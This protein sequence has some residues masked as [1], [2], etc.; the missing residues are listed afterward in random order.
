MSLRRGVSVC[1][2][3]KPGKNVLRA[4]H[5][6]D[7]DAAHSIKNLQLQ[8]SY[9]NLYETPE[10]L[11]CPTIDG[12][13]GRAAVRGSVSLPCGRFR[14][15]MLVSVG[16][17]VVA[18]PSLFRRSLRRERNLESDLC[19]WHKDQCKHI[20]TTM[21]FVSARGF[22]F[23]LFVTSQFLLVPSTYYSALLSATLQA[24]WCHF[25]DKKVAVFFIVPKF[26]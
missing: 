25:L 12:G 16:P 3:L 2:R 22:N 15:V 9:W 11:T 24:V 14:G 4:A 20:C 5:N 21:G 7:R 18:R 19:N 1:R 6:F 26:K 23:S 13:R 17:V 10:R 8:N